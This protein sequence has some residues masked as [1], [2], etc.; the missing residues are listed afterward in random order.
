M[1][2]KPTARTTRVASAIREVLAETIVRTSRDPRLT[3]LVITDVKV[4]ADLGIAKV[5]YHGLSDRTARAD[6]QRALDGA[7]GFLRRAVAERIQLRVV[8]ELR[9]FYD[10]VLDEAR[11]I[12][13]LLAGLTPAQSAEVDIEGEQQHSEPGE[14]PPQ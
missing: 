3:D 13:T 10:D 1:Q 11:R 7:A 6:M 5:Y 2:P 14:D 9:F 4:T 8:P 12:E